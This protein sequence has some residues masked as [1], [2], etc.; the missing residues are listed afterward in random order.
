MSLLI[1]KDFCPHL[2]GLPDPQRLECDVQHQRH[3]RDS[4]SLP[5]SGAV[6]PGA[7]RSGPGGESVDSV[8]LRAIWR[9]RTELRGE[10]TGADHP[11]DSGRGS[12]RDVQM[13]SG[14]RELSQ[15]AD[16]SHRASG[17]R[18]ARPFHLQL[19]ALELNSPKRLFKPSV[20]VWETLRDQ[21]RRDANASLVLTV[22]FS[23]LMCR[24]CRHEEVYIA[25]LEHF[26]TSMV[27]SKP[28]EPVPVHSSAFTIFYIYIKVINVLRC[29]AHQ[30]EKSFLDLFELNFNH[31]QH[32]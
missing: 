30:W 8:Q 2:S 29:S 13:D 6:W 32:I 26:I 4:C 17:E 1:F 5:E 21:Q 20:C 18:A 31:L 15:D 16:G 19:P 25:G 11:K 22:Q 9:R 7:V 14:H 3:P 28:K 10:R 24:F 27:W 12:D 23:P